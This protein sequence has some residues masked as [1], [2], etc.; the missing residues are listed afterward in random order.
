MFAQTLVED[1]ALS[2]NYHSVIV[3]SIQEQLGDFKAHM[4]GMDWK[5]LSSTVDLDDSKIEELDEFVPVEKTSE[6]TDG[7]VGQVMEDG[8]NNQVGGKGTLDAEAV[9]WWESWQKR[10]KKQVLCRSAVTNS[11]RKKRKVA[12]DT[13]AP[14]ASTVHNDKLQAGDADEKTMQED[15]RILIKVWISVNQIRRCAHWL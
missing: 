1:Y 10:C 5:P 2:P 7:N 14:G 15:L 4:V 8:D 6:E 3:K 12:L 13:P 11:R 9:R